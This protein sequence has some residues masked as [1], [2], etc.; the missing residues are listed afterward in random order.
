[1]RTGFAEQLEE[2]ERQIVNDLRG[3]ADALATIASA[4]HTLTE[5]RIAS[6]ADHASKL[7]ARASQAHAD[8]VT[9]TARQTPVASDLRLVLAM[10][11]L[12]HH[13]NLIANQFDLIA[14]QLAQ[15]DPSTRDRENVAQTLVRM[16][17]LASTQ[18]R[19]ATNAFRTRDLASARDL[20]ADDDSLDQLNLE[21]CDTIAHVEASPDERQLGFHQVLIARSL[22]R[23]GDNAVDIAEQAAFVVTAEHQEFSDASHPRTRSHPRGPQSAAQGTN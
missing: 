9:V 7:R 1:M 15:V 22:E 14:Q 19:K 11:D 8:L 23:I 5:H 2:L 21:I 17:E 16:S 12:A 13:A 3:A 4:V 6:I 10:I 20:D 18:L